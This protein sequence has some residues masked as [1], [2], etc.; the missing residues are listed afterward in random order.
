[1]DL[2]AL[3]RSNGG[4]TD[5][6]LES[7]NTPD[8]DIDSVLPVGQAEDH[9]EIVDSDGVG[10]DHDSV[11]SLPD[12]DRYETVSEVDSEDSR[13]IVDSLPDLETD[14]LQTSSGGILADLSDIPDRVNDE[15][16]CWVC[17]LSESET[18]DAEWVRPCKCDGSVGYVHQ[19]CVKRWVEEKQKSDI[20][21]DV[22]CPQCQTKYRFV[23]P[24]MVGPFK[25]MILGEQLLNS[26]VTIFT[27]GGIIYG[28]N[29]VTVFYSRN[30]IKAMVA[31]RFD[32]FTDG[33]CRSLEPY[34][35]ILINNISDVLKSMTSNIPDD[36]FLPL[37][38]VN[39]FWFKAISKIRSS[40]FFVNYAPMELFK[41]TAISVSIPWTLYNFRK[42]NWDEPLLRKLDDLQNIKSR[43]EPVTSG[44]K[45][46]RRLIGG[47]VMPFASRI[48]GD[49]VFGTYSPGKRFMLGAVTYLFVKGGISFIRKYKFR[50]WLRARKVKGYKEGDDHENEN[51][52][53]QL[54]F[55]LEFLIT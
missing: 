45:G 37:Q 19:D 42:I 28:I 3:H 25:C 24:K 6:A 17:F 53:P 41:D 10:S 26:G 44:G 48:L 1:M 21:L 33:E 27:I 14:P 34:R 15:R 8:E 51:A 4:N 7:D 46:T 5:N 22:E 18:P 29:L 11:Y 23:F 49:A 30:V 55:R 2:S 31:E 52:A 35:E 40:L 36:L 9:Q 54:P 16:E 47:L 32:I 20:N 13:S 12:D 50:H 38:V 43:Y 39:Q